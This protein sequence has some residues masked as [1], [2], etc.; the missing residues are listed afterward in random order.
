MDPFR[1]YD[2]GARAP[3]LHTWVWV[4][5]AWGNPRVLR[6]RALLGYHCYFYLDVAS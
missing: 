6:T 1:G 5:K 4:S 3:F 2:Y